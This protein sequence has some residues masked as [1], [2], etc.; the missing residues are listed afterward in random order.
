MPH[1][2]MLAPLRPSAVALSAVLLA[3]SMLWLQRAGAD[4]S[5][6]LLLAMVAG[7]GAG[8]A[9]LPHGNRR[10]ARHERELIAALGEPLLAAHPAAPAAVRALCGQLEAHWFVGSRRLL[11]IVDL[12]DGHGAGALACELANAFAAMGE[13]TLLIDAD[14]RSPQ[15]HA[16]FGVPRGEGLADCLGGLDRRDLRLVACAEN[17]ALL[18]AGRVREHPLELL[19]RARLRRLLDAAAQPFRVVLVCT[20]PVSRGPDFEIFA[21]LAGGALVFAG[22]AAGAAELAALGTRLQRCAAR[23]VGTI[24]ERD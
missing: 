16:R 6:V 10:P 20:T 12:S 1:P 18:T 7:M 8:V 23:V 24:L 15:L 14:F 21:A 5:A 11:P 13:P 22:R 3:G 17:L 9:L 4:N 2:S 19:S